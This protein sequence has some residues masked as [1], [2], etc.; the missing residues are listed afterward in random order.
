[1][2]SPAFQAQLRQA[3]AAEARLGRM[4]GSNGSTF[5]QALHIRIC[6]GVVSTEH[7]QASMHDQAHG[8]TFGS[9]PFPGYAAYRSSGCASTCH[10]TRC[11][12]SSLHRGPFKNLE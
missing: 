2:M 9:P 11:L 5:T 1:M 3:Q 4:A 12:T 10:H 7:M 6:S 8:K